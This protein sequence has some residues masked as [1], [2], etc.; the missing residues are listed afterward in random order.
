MYTFDAKKTKDD[1]VTWI[2]NWFK[3]NGDGCNAIIGVSGGKDSTVV[4]DLCCKALGKDRVIGILMPCGSQRDIDDS[5]AVVQHLGIKWY[6]V[7][8]FNAV[9]HIQTAVRDN[10][11]NIL[12]ATEINLPAR[13]RMATLYAFAQSLNGRV[14]NTCNLSEDWVGYATKYGDGAGDF[15]PLSQLT[16]TE[17]LQIGDLLDLPK[18]LIHKTPSDGLCGAT[19]EER[20]GFSYAI[21]DRYIREGVID[22]IE[23]QKKIE[24]MHNANLF[25]L[26]PMAAF[27]PNLSEV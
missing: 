25:K 6:E 11:T 12:P 9:D 22:D 17:I 1:C 8:I 4:G 27:H 21:L 13:I 5:H 24:I 15:S 20:F 3:E 10:I 26:E 14:A 2:R 7:N 23:I 19:D 16:V 18:H